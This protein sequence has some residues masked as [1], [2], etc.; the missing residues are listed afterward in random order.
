[1]SLT[2][3]FSP[4]IACGQSPVDP[5]WAISILTLPPDFCSTA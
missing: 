5:E 4:S 3:I 1:M 2:P